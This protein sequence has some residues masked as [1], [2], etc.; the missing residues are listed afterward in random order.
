M[1]F[2][3]PG[4]HWREFS[5]GVRLSLLVFTFLESYN[6]QWDFVTFFQI[7]SIINIYHL[8]YK[9]GAG[10]KVEIFL[11]C[12]ILW[13]FNNFILT[14]KGELKSWILAQ[15]C[16][17]LII[18]TFVANFSLFVI[19]DQRASQIIIWCFADFMNFSTGISED[20][21]SELM[22]YIFPTLFKQTDI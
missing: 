17:L 22:T 10:R 18:P 2:Y 14:E 8:K 12:S 13:W 1:F 5:K 21:G 9:I 15:W 7:D 4:E 6:L 11:R 16:S 19:T 3:I 20:L